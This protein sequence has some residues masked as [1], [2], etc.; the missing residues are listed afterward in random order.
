MA[1]FKTRKGEGFSE[2]KA[3]RGITIKATGKD[4]WKIRA[5][6]KVIATTYDHDTMWTT[7]IFAD[8]EDEVT[9]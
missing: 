5:G 7:L 3:H 8:P 1:T 9:T 4:V 6:M 2:A